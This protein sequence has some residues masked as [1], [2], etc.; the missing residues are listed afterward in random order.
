L[1]G[2]DAPKLRGSFPL[3]ERLWHKSGVE[4]RKR[5]RRTPPPLDQQALQ[6]L[7]LRYAGKYATTRAKLR[8]YLARKVRER[9]WG[10]D[11]PPDL[12]VLANR[13]AELG[14]VDDASYALGQSRSLSARGYG[15]RRL[16]DKLRLAGVEQADGS[17]ANRL[18]D[19]EAVGAALRFARR[20]RLGPYA[21]DHADRPQREKW[22]AAMIRAGH[23][24]GL[25]R[26][27][28][29]LPPGAEIDEEQLSEINRL[30]TN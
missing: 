2:H 24:F 6:E 23:S 9:G 19:V 12:D 16:A 7:A 4:P 5:P 26:A 18:A 25:A 28:A 1:G 10:C 29:S 17:A 27:L 11:S 13:F 30:G 15:K 8:A 22:I 21:A 20:R 14:Y 3:G